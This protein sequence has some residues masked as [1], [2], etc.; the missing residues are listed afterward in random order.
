MRHTVLLESSCNNIFLPF[1]L[2]LFC[3]CPCHSHVKSYNLIALSWILVTHCSPIEWG[4]RGA[5]SL[6]QLDQKKSCI[7]LLPLECWPSRCCLRGCPLLQPSHY[8]GQSPSYTVRPCIE[9]A[10]HSPC[11]A[12]LSS[13]PGQESRCQESER[14]FQMVPGLAD[15]VIQ[16]SEL[17]TQALWNRDTPSLLALP[18]SWPEKSGHIA[19][20]AV[21]FL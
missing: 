7:H 17:R 19:L 20:T 9:P 5:T 1:Y 12:H 21:L 6:L 4:R 11:W 3:M 14:S 18:N 10:V 13:P 16:A 15:P 8:V 2:L